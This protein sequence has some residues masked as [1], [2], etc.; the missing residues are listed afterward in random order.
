MLMQR[1]APP[2]ADSSDR[3]LLSIFYVDFIKINRFTYL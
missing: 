1:I 3:D 2:V